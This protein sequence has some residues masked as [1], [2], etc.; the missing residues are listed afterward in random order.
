MLVSVS[1]S[2]PC[3]NLPWEKK[4]GVE[5]REVKG[6]GIEIEV[7]WEGHELE[8]SLGYRDESKTSL[9]YIARPCVKKSKRR[10]G[11]KEKTK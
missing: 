2:S 6:K 9:G 8:A 7:G 4:Q 5:S 10:K 11:E 3:L 1:K